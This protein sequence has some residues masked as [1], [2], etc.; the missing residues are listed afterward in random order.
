[1]VI[2]I[3]ITVAVSAADKSGF[4]PDSMGGNWQPEMSIVTAT[5]LSQLHWERTVANPPEHWARLALAVFLNGL[6]LYLGTAFVVYL[7]FRLT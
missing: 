2:L 6:P 4:L 1:M 3:F 7:V 5:I